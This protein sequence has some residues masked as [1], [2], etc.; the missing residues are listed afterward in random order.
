[1]FFY[2][3]KFSIRYEDIYK[4]FWRGELTC[5]SFEGKIKKNTK[6]FS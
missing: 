2:F 6:I 1:M 5:F 4:P 3:S